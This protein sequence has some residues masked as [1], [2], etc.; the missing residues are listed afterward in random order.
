MRAASSDA[1][2]RDAAPSRY[3]PEVRVA[4]SG[5]APVRDGDVA[6]EVELE[7]VLG[8]QPQP[9]VIAGASWGPRV[10]IAVA[11]SGAITAK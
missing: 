10:R 2:S 6:D 7:Q 4:P 3:V 9:G 11:A 1:A 8:A 5:S